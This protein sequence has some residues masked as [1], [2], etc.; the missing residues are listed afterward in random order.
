MSTKSYRILTS[1]MVIMAIAQAEAQTAPD[2]PRLVV[3]VVIDQLRTDYMEAFSPFY[4]GQG[5]MRLM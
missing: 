2:V 5:F 3:N 4:S 1:V